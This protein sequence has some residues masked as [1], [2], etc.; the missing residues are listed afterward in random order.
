VS[1]I[2]DEMLM[3]H[4]DGELG[5]ADRLRVVAYLAQ[6]PEANRRLEVFSNTRDGL[7]QLLNAPMT[8]PVPARLLETVLRP[9]TD[10]ASAGA[11]TQTARVLPWTGRSYPQ[12]FRNGSGTFLT[13]RAIASLAATLLIGAASGWALHAAQSRAYQ[14]Q[15]IVTVNGTSLLASGA[16]MRTLEDTS[17]GAAV[18][19]QSG[20]ERIVV[21]PVM[22]FRQ[23]GGEYCRQYKLEQSSG[24]KMGGIACRVSDGAW[25]LEMQAALGR[26]TPSTGGV[27]PAAADK[28]PVIEAAVDR[29]IAGNALGLE[30]EQAIIAQRWHLAP[31]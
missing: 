14:S 8:E 30:D 29:M 31:K 26:G 24:Q 28:S 6:N 15:Q 19:A 4:A 5:D 18:T 27:V 25:R 12:K 23:S 20:S 10:A 3:A 1:D 21:T 22:T 17:S 9:A 7:R 2:S 13:P 16:L 11:G